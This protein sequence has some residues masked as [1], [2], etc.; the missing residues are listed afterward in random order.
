MDHNPLTI[1][2]ERTFYIA[3]RQRGKCLQTNG[4]S[5]ARLDRSRLY[6]QTVC[7]RMDCRG[8]EGNRSVGPHRD[9]AAN[10]VAF[11]RQFPAPVRDRTRCRAPRFSTL[12]LADGFCEVAPIDYKPR[13]E[14]AGAMRF[15]NLRIRRMK[16]A[17]PPAETTPS[18]D[19]AIC[20]NAR[21][22]ADSQDLAAAIKMIRLWTEKGHRAEALALLKEALSVNTQYFQ[23]NCAEF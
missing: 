23:R 13:R 9:H 6:Y 1:D 20:W 5:A 11:A 12:P 4:I 15:A 17:P 10:V 3:T 21:N 2:R 8:C 16:L 19:Q 14:D 7:L 22:R 18:A